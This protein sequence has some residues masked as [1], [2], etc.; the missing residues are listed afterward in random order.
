MQS[1]ITECWGFKKIWETYDDFIV[2]ET[3]RFAKSLFGM[4]ALLHVRRLYHCMC[5]VIMPCT[6][7]VFKPNFFHNAIPNDALLKL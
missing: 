3:H 1:G 6:K 5:K 4:K 7:F 2:F